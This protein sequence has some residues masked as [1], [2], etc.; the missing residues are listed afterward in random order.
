MLG[1][2]YI[3]GRRLL[4]QTSVVLPL[5]VMWAILAVVVLTTKSGITNG[6]AAIVESGG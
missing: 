1:W 6:P 3:R 4:R 5:L 2:A